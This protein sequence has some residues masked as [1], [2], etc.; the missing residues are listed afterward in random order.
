M[1]RYLLPVATSVALLV[2]C[3]LVHGFWTDRWEP[4][5]DPAAVAAR[6]D[7]LA[8]DLGD[9]QGEALPVGPRETRGLSGYLVRRYVNRRTGDAV[10][11]ALMSGPP[12]VVSIHTPS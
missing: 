3:G 4:A 11:V 9:W 12:R 10:T 7:A 6:F 1:T 2:A 8:T 5:P